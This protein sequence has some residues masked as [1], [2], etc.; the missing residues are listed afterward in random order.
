[1]KTVHA[2]ICGILFLALLV[3]PGRAVS[4]ILSLPIAGDAYIEEAHATLILPKKPGSVTGDVAIR[5]G[6]MMNDEVT[7]VQGV[8][9]NSPSG[10][11]CND[12]GEKWCSFAYISTLDK[13]NSKTQIWEQS[14]YVDG[15]LSSTVA[16]S[17]GQVG[18]AFYLTILCAD[19][20]ACAEHPEHSW[21]N[22]SVVLNKAD[23]NFG[24][25]KELKFNATGGNMTSSDGKT[26][27]IDD[28]KVPAQKAN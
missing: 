26:W 24:R 11:Y 14:T 9:S 15:K 16:S 20:S 6:I 27:K 1:M 4:D 5:S 19:G 23:R 21:T 10:S 7:L 18:I 22:V 25:R 28:I 12:G 2:A 17:R 3:S 13:F 8:V